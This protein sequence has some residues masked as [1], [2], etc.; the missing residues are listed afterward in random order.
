MVSAAVSERLQTTSNVLDVLRAGSIWQ[1]VPTDGSLNKGLANVVLAQTGIEALLIIDPQGTILASSREELVGR[2]FN[3]FTPQAAPAPPV[4]PALLQVSPPLLTPSGDT[5]VSLGKTLIDAEG[6]FRGYVVA[7]IHPSFFFSVLD[8]I[9]YVDDVTSWVVHGKGKVIHR[10]PDPQKYVG[11][12]LSQKPNS[13]FSRF[14]ASG[15]PR[16]LLAAVGG[17]TGQHHLTAFGF[18]KPTL[19]SADTPLLVSVSRNTDDVFASWYEDRKHKLVIFVGV[20]LFGTFGMWMYQRRRAAYDALRRN[21][22]IVRAQT[23]AQLRDS[24][25]RFRNLFEHLPVP[26]HSLDADRCWLDAN[27]QMANLLGFESPVQM[28]GKDF[29]T[30]CEEPYRSNFD[31]AFDQFKRKHSVDGELVLRRLDD[32]LVTVLISGRMQRDAEGNFLR[33]HCILFDITARRALEEHVLRLNE[34]LESKV[35]QRTEELALA[36]EALSRLARKDTLTGLPNRLMANERLESEFKLMKRTGTPFS[37]LVLD[38]DF[39]KQVNDS[40][41]HAA[42]DHVLERTAQLL[43]GCIRETD[44]AARFGGEEFVVVLPL[45]PLEAACFVAEKIRKAVEET[46]DP[47]AGTITVSIG[48]SEASPEDSG[49]EAVIRRADEGLYAA[50]REGR[51]RVVS[52]ASSVAGADNGRSAS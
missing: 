46:P 11:L 30:F 33:T 29:Y 2:S 36:N 5:G 37:V 13:L 20:M 52:V 25:T 8:S 27:Q 40:Y 32:K 18:I 15:E 34:E 9:R 10:W 17:V 26:Y 38:V 44:L 41:G 7:T 51:N 35:L 21:E 12:D 22:E 3:P 6:R 16:G 43:S 42:G 49:Q 19:A 50:K 31:N 28:L 47:V 45:T 4:A 39:F 24:E 23:E 1:N 14:V 48:V